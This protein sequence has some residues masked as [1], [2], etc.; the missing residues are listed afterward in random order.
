MTEPL[1][2]PVVIGWVDVDALVA[3]ASWAAHADPDD[4]ADALSSAYEECL[5]YEPL[6]NNRRVWTPDTVGPVPAR[7]ARAQALQARASIRESVSNGGDAQGF[8]GVQVTVFPLD[9]RVKQLLRPRKAVR[10]GPR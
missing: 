4:L 3:S 8:D 7:L 5:L 6:D 9:W 10:K 1:P 2:D